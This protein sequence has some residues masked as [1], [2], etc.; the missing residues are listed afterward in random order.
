MSGEDLI[1]YFIVASGLPKELAERE[2]NSLILR[3][4][5]EASSIDLDELREI[6]VDYLQDVL[7]EAK[8]ANSIETSYYLRS[9]DMETS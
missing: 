2:L 7:T 5:K 6:L 4:G 8:K 1:G 9:T 3:S